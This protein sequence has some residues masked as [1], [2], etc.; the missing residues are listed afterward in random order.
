MEALALEASGSGTVIRFIDREGIAY[1][2]G[3]VEEAKGLV[4]LYMSARTDE[5]RAR[6]KSL[7]KAINS[8]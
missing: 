1:R 6:I 8:G 7:L 5:E 4:L 3:K 2:Q